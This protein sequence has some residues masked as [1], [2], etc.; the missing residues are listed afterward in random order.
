M[1]GS[2][3]ESLGQMFRIRRPDSRFYDNSGWCFDYFNALVRYG[4][5]ID[6]DELRYMKYILMDIN[7]GAIR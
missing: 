6:F 3:R 5:D 7:K 2:P 1:V 4:P